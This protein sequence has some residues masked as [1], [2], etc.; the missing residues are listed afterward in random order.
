MSGLGVVPTGRLMK[1]AGRDALAAGMSG[2][3]RIGPGKLAVGG[4]FT[5]M[6]IKDNMAQGDSFGTSA[7]KAGVYNMAMASHP[8]LTTAIQMAPLAVQGYSA[9]TTYR[10][11]RAEEL[12]AIKRG[13]NGTVG[14]GWQ[15]TQQSLT[16]RQAAVQQ[17]QGNKL[18]ART[19]LGG[20]ARIF[21]T[22]YYR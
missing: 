20:E 13:R 14:S 11:G 1:E 17:I 4:V 19:A 18:N 6:Q 15:D 7:F 2:A 21:G 12:Q 3:K 8:L 22:S 5:A 10:R 9:A 16:M